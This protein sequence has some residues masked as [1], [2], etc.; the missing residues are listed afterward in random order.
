MWLPRIDSHDDDLGQSQAGCC[1]LT[2]A[3]NGASDGY[4]PRIL[5][6]TKAARLLVHPRWQGFE[7]AQKNEGPASR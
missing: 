5:R 1:Y 6:F 2:G 4:R 7:Y 3:I